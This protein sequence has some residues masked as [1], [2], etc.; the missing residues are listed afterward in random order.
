[1]KGTINYFLKWVYSFT[2]PPAIQVI[3]VSLHPY[4][5]LVLSLFH[6]LF[7]MV[8]G[9]KSHYSFSV[10]IS[11]IANTLEHPFMCLLS[12]YP[13]RKT[14]LRKNV[15]LCLLFISNWSHLSLMLWVCKFFIY[16]RYAKLLFLISCYNIWGWNDVM[17]SLLFHWTTLILLP[18]R[19]PT[20]SIPK[21]SVFI[22]EQHSVE[23]RF[24]LSL[25]TLFLLLLI[26]SAAFFK[27]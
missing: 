17:K 13:L 6:L 14:L 20:I 23:A 11:L 1:M 18:L 9:V 5:H 26:C 24:Q 10:C 21:P 12:V 22:E 2:F 27:N 4:L 7:L 15:C 16:S 25:N 8:Y 19:K 3:P